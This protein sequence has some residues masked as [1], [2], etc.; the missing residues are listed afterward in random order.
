METLA[1]A[2]GSLREKGYRIVL[3]GG[4]DEVDDAATFSKLIGGE[5]TD[6]VGRCKLRETMGVSTHLKLMLG[7]DTGL[8]HVAAA[9]GC[10]TLT[11]FGT[12]PAEKWG[13][14]YPPHRAIQAPN[15]DLK[16]VDPQL[17]VEAAVDLMASNRSGPT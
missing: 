17:L 15:K 3:L 1:A 12:V 13:H 2:A 14:N 16:L 5:V 4:V 9:M 8:M 7:S 6:L 11:V 10:P